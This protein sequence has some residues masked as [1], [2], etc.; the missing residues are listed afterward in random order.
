MCKT[1]RWLFGNRV[2]LFYLPHLLAPNAQRV[3]IF[4]EC[5][6]DVY[7]NDKE[8]RL[9]VENA[10]ITARVDPQKLSYGHQI[11]IARL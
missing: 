5:V 9:C 6:F 3:K 1:Y 2:C 7:A 8:R 11:Q 4:A 10:P